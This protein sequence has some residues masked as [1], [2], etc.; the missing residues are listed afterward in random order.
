MRGLFSPE[1]G[2]NPRRKESRKRV[3]GSNSTKLAG[4]RKRGPEPLTNPEINF[5]KFLPYIHL[6]DGFSV[7]MSLLQR[8]LPR[9]AICPLPSHY[10]FTV[11]RGAITLW[12][13]SIDLFPRVWSS[14]HSLL[15]C[16]L[17]EVSRLPILLTVFPQS[18]CTYLTHVYTL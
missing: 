7:Q 10:L 12:N 8:G 4:H 13:P 5:K 16:K 18:T 6:S 3:G 1:E 14:P 9:L 2:G 17:P 11:L 15:E